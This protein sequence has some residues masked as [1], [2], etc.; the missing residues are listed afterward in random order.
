MDEKF[1]EPS[2]STCALWRS[3]TAVNWLVPDRGQSLD[4]SYS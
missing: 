1:Y 3:R 2:D 4:R